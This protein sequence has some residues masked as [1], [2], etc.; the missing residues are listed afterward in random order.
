[1]KNRLLVVR[2]DMARSVIDALVNMGAKVE[3]AGHLSRTDLILG[4][5]TY[6][7]AVE[8]KVLLRV[9]GDI[10][11]K[12]LKDIPGVVRVRSRTMPRRGPVIALD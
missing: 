2:R 5:V 3:V 1:M 7:G 9:Y 6:T 10:P 11:R 12:K 4:D 8:P